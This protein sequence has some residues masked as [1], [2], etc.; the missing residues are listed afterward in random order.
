MG[1]RQAR[2]SAAQAINVRP[3]G[4]RP[5]ATRLSVARYPT[6]A[7][8]SRTKK[9]AEPSS[10]R[11]KPNVRSAEPMMAPLAQIPCLARIGFVASSDALVVVGARARSPRREQCGRARRSCGFN[12][13]LGG[14]LTQVRRHVDVV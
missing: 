14:K 13:Q 5:F 3:E 12:A 4:H 8:A 7:S 10:G 11:T 6:A 9:G 2:A 1:T